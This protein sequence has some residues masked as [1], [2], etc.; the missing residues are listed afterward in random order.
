MSKFK[1]YLETA[2]EK[3]LRDTWTL[4]KNWDKGAKKYD[5]TDPEIDSSEEEAEI[6]KLLSSIKEVK[7]VSYDADTDEAHINVEKGTE[8]IKNA[9]EKALKKTKY[10]LTILYFV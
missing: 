4:K 3:Q 1:E 8:E 5:G 6:E 10:A 2:R 7:G 9:V